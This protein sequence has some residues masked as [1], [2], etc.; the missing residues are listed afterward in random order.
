MYPKTTTSTGWFDEFVCWM[1][2]HDLLKPARA[3]M[4]AA[5]GTETK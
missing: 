2:M 1:A 4:S 3:V 5:N